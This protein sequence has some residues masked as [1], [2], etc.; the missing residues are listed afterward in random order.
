MTMLH[1]MFP[2]FKQ[3]D[4]INSLLLEGSQYMLHWQADHCH[5]L[6][7]NSDDQMDLQDYYSK[8][9]HPVA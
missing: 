3:N 2:K 1:K 9:F 6:S 4:C 7:S 8:K 5:L